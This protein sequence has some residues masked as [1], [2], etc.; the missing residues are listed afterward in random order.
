MARK[1]DTD[2]ATERDAATEPKTRET[3]RVVRAFAH[4]GHYY[5]GRDVPEIGE[6]PE[7]VI[8]DRVDRGYIQPYRAHVP[9]AAE[10][11]TPAQE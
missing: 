9:E 10:T 4:D 5:A 8:K 3:Y 7:D 6:L 2:G 1:N 11:T